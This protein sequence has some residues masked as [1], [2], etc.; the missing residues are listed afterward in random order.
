MSILNEIARRFQSKT[1]SSGQ[2]PLT[3][4]EALDSIS[5]E[6][7]HELAARMDNNYPYAHPLYAG[8]MLKPPHAIARTAYAFAQN[9]NP[10]NHALDGGKETSK[11]ELEAVAEIAK[12]F[13]RSTHLGHLTSGGTMANLE[14]LWIA[15]Q[16][17]PNKRVLASASAHYTHER[18]TS[19]LKI[20]FSKIPVVHNYP[21]M[22]LDAL[23]AE[24]KKGD[25]GTVVAT[26]GT[27]GTGHVEPIDQIV[28]LCTKYGARCHIDAAYG[29]YFILA[30]QDA[31]ESYKKFQAISEADSIV[32]D[33]HKHGLQPYGCGCVLFSDPG[34]G[35]FY[36]H[37]SPYTYFTSDEL[38]LG[39]IS[40]ECSRPGASA[41]ALWATQQRFPLILGGEMAQ[42]LND[43]RKAAQSLYSSLQ[44]SENW[45]LPF[46]PELDI[47]IFAPKANKASE[48]SARSQFVFDKAEQKGLYLALYNLP[49]AQFK[50]LFPEIE[51]DTDYVTFCRSTL[52]K[53]S[54]IHYVGEIVRILEDILA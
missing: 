51:A 11:M 38:H 6:V 15:G 13:G 24:L 34:V 4:Q 52:M 23:E 7:L 12:M 1:D 44:T 54:H 20:P 17:H 37:D 26:A 31:P 19:V 33:P 3:G 41:A 46:Q 36:L 53:W 32:I 9:I 29:G 21:V 50:A 49:S 43:C 25:V 40:L 22:D 2:Y 14:A 42:G 28:E 35:K 10:N 8:Q 47:L 39:E 5:E 16:I 27:T 18:I 45:L 48:I 30:T